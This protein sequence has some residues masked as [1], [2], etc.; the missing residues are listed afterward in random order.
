MHVTHT[1]PSLQQQTGA[2]RDA[3]QA[4]MASEPETAAL[5]EAL[6]SGRGTAKDRQNALE[7]NIREEAKKLRM[8]E[9]G[10]LTCVCCVFDCIIMV[11][12]LKSELQTPHALPA[13]S[14]VPCIHTPCHACTHRH[15]HTVALDSAT[16]GMSSREVASRAVVDLES[17]SFAAGAHFNSSKSC[18]L[19]KGSFRTTHKG[20]EEVHVPALKPK[21]F[22]E[23]AW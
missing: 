8:A 23:G 13:S 18:Q 22:A 17:L 1:Q 7:R 15:T 3:V 6:R 20:Y 10:A 2:E 11:I 16:G 19:P 5:L 9:A 4:A 21:P 14:T 12:C